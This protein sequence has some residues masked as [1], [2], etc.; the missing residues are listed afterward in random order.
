MSVRET[1]TERRKQA[2]SNAPFFCV[3]YIGWHEK[4]GPRH[5]V[6]LLTSNDSDLR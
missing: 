4:V 2:R 5:R 6:G 1:E 3:L